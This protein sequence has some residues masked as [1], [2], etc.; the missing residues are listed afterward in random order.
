MEPENKIGEIF[1]KTLE[2]YKVDCDGDIWESIDYQLDTIDTYVR[3]KSFNINFWLKIAA[4]VV[5]FAGVSFAYTLFF[6]PFNVSEIIPKNF[7]KL[8]YKNNSSE[9]TTILDTISSNSYL[10]SENIPTYSHNDNLGKANTVLPEVEKNKDT[11]NLI[12]SSE[13]DNIDNYQTGQKNVLEK[14]I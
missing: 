7:S 3:K 12:E 14:K 2:N 9:N 13:N 8:N 4:S 11:T 5:L 1:K 6:V 10:N